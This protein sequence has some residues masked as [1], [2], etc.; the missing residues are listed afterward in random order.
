MAMTEVKPAQ[1]PEMP[2][3]KWAK[4]AKPASETRTGA[5][6]TPITGT[7]KSPTPL[8]RFVEIIEEAASRMSEDEVEE[9]NRKTAQLVHMLHAKHCETCESDRSALASERKLRRELQ[10]ALQTAY[11]NLLGWPKE[12]LVVVESA[13]ARAAEHDK[14]QSND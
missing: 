4:E 11:D 6:G 12:I 13:L 1:Y 7:F 2:S 10:E 8:E 3:D 9:A 14:E 5:V